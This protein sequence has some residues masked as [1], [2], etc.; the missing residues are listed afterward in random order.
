MLTRR[1]LLQASASILALSGLG[2]WRALDLPAAAAGSV[3]LSAPEHLLVQALAE[4]LFPPGSSL[5]VSA[6]GMELAAEVDDL[7][8][9]RLEPVVGLVFRYT[10]AGLNDGTLVSRG[11]RFVNLPLSERVDVLARWAEPGVLARRLAYDALRTVVGMVFFCRPEV[12]RAIG[13]APPCAEEAA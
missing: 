6:V 8:G 13:W 2:A 11:A 3:C 1:H 7:L 9:D 4:A 5:G 12:T 10:L